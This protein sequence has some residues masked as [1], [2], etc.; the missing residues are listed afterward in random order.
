MMWPSLAGRGDVK[1]KMSKYKP[2]SNPNNIEKMVRVLDILSEEET[3]KVTILNWRG[4][5]YKRNYKNYGNWVKYVSARSGNPRE[6]FIYWDSK[7]EDEFL[8]EATND[9][10]KDKKYFNKLE[11]YFLKSYADFKKITDQIFAKGADF[12]KNRTSGELIKILEKHG[13][14]HRRALA[15]YYVIYDLVN[16]LPRLVK[17]EL[18]KFSSELKIKNMGKALQ[19][20]SSIGINSMV[21]TERLDFLE[22]LIKIQKIHK[23]SKNWQ[24]KKIKKIIFGHWYEFGGCSFKHDGNYYKLEDF[25]KRFLKHLKTNAETEIRKINN[26]ERKDRKIVEK[27][28]SGLKKYPEIT[29][30]I[31]WL[32]KMMDYRN[33]DEEY[34]Y[35]YALHCWDF[36]LEIID[37]LKLEE[38][39]DFWLLSKKEIV[40]GLLGKNNPKKIVKE[41]KLKG[42]TIKQV[43]NTIKVW[44]GVK[45]EDWHEVEIE[46]KSFLKGFVAYKGKVKGRVKVVFDPRGDRT[47]F[48]EGDILVTSMT[49][50]DF[51]PLIKKAAAI[52]TDEGGLLCHAAIVARELKTP[53]LIGTKTASK[54]LK[55]GDLVE[56]DANFGKVTVIKK[57]KN[58]LKTIPTQIQKT[59]SLRDR[60]VLHLGR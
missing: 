36:Y 38:A 10:L 20:F 44:T 18:D 49:T 34:Y 15:G 25:D 22:E 14:Y 55:D 41:R 3:L 50:P 32:R 37:R 42:A 6:F 12:Y 57:L 39:D 28:L 45:K 1:I 5:P 48:E 19:I 2:F 30:H 8:E 11:K 29:K 56:V 7:I 53:C 40:E 33:C 13:Y 46:K 60:K 9:L 27:I 58:N 21:K 54:T 17:K 26:E 43:G 51:V 16:L 59:S 35:N 4:N 31:F 23:D 24:D 47:K 52:V